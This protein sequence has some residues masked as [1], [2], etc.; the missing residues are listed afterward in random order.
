MGGELILSDMDSHLSDA[1]FILRDLQELGNHLAQQIVQESKVVTPRGEPTISQAGQNN[2]AQIGNN[3]QANIDTGRRLSKKDR[4]RLINALMGLSVKVRFS[5]MLAAPDASQYAYDL[6]EA[7][8]AAGIEV[9]D[10]P[11]QVTPVAFTGAP[12]SGT[13]VAWHEESQGSNVNVSLD[14]P[15]G[16]ILEALANAHASP[17]HAHVGPEEP[18]GIFTIVVGLKPEGEKD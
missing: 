17:K 1:E 9:V 6:R 14:S 7:F 11:F 5:A 16:K 13:E 3:N 15:Q 12:W 4:S 18:E 8:K 10:T 2:I